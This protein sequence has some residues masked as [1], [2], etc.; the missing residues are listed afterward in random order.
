MF[1]HLGSILLQDGV[2]ITFRT[3][4]CSSFTRKTL[5]PSSGGTH[6]LR[7]NDLTSFEWRNLLPSPEGAVFAS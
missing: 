3:R 6:F 2:S 5:L 4:E 7:P 1:S